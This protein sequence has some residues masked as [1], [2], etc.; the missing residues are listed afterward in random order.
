MDRTAINAALQKNH[1]AFIVRIHKL[2]AE[3]WNTSLNGKWS[4]AQQLDHILR[5]V[6][7]VHMAMG[8]PKWFLRMVFGKPNRD[9]RSYVALCQR[10]HEKLTA[11]G[12]ASGR[13]VPPPKP[14]RSVEQ[15]SAELRKLIDRLNGRVNKWSEKDLDTVLLPHPLLGRITSRE[16]LYF[17]IYH[18]QHHHEL[19]ERDCGHWNTPSSTTVVNA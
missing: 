5:S 1:E 17:T 6:G 12:R 10:Y 7:P 8:L 11:G 15:M 13:F 3:Q 4:P 18:A 16:M 2:P 9:A 19:V 14:S